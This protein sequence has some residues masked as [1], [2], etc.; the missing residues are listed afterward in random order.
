MQKLIELLSEKFP[1]I[2]IV[3]MVAF[4]M[5]KMLGAI[6]KMMS[7]NRETISQQVNAK[8]GDVMAEIRTYKIRAEEAADSSRKILAE[9]QN[10][11][12]SI[13][14]K[15]SSHQKD[16]QNDTS[17][18]GDMKKTIPVATDIPN[19][20]TDES[21]SDYSI[22]ELIGFAQQKSD[23]KSKRTICKYILECGSAIAQELELAGDIMRE[24][25]VHDL[26]LL[27]YEESH[28]KDP[29]RNSAT[30]EML[31]LTAEV[32]FSK[33]E[34]SLEKLKQV[35]L[36]KPDRITFSRVANALIELGRY[37]ELIAI[38]RA[39]IEVIGDRFPSLRALA[40][41]NIAVGLKQTGNIDDSIS[42][43][44]EAFRI[45]PE[46]ENVLKPYLGLLQEQRKY[47]EYL[48]VSRKLIDIDP[49]DINYYRLH[50]SALVSL[51]RFDEAGSWFQKTK[52]LYKSPL[53]QVRLKELEI[54][55]NAAANNAIN[56]EE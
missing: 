9:V 5:I 3:I 21:L 32:D 33:R 50:I 29:E 16:L 52:L 18:D 56:T 51:G 44:T 19:T 31:A 47:E 17:P 6:G 13:E 27:L 45:T 20:L 49:S 42:A 55:I 15:S 53:D 40:L 23:T 37:D 10:L 7:E 54:K 39:F 41:R 8:I 22:N 2:V 28:R 24:A 4:A 26:A 48:K 14:D 1:E 35:L 38:S 30:I 11:G 12:T 43:Y 46:D 36:E 25:D 34:E